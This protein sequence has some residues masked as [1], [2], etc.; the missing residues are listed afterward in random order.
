MKWVINYSLMNLQLQED[1]YNVTHSLSSGISR[2]QPGCKLVFT[3][4]ISFSCR[5]RTIFLFGYLVFELEPSSSPFF[6]NLQLFISIA[7]LMAGTFPIIRFLSF[8]FFFFKKNNSHY[9]SGAR[10]G[11][12][13]TVF[14]PFILLSL[15][16]HYSNILLLLLVSTASNQLLLPLQ[17]LLS[18]VVL[19]LFFLLCSHTPVILFEW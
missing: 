15:F 16:N 8:F 12:L 18:F 10:H 19:M 11:L 13:P 14:Y 5:E 4:K 9:K 6:L 7:M 3:L 17:P 2:F 1:I